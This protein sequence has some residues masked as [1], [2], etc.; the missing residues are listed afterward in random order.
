MN[1]PYQRGLWNLTYLLHSCVL[2]FG[3][4]VI[5]GLFLEGQHPHF[6]TQH[7]PPC[8]LPF[9]TILHILLVALASSA[10]F[11]LLPW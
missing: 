3:G 1:L 7:R 11:C 8:P 5:L 6:P 4:W 10:S 2:R 9:T